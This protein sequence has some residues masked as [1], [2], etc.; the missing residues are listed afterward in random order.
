MITNCETRFADCQLKTVAWW[1][2]TLV[3]ETR[4]RF[5]SPSLLLQPTELINWLA[6]SLSLTLTTSSANNWSLH[7]LANR[8][9]ELILDL[10]NICCKINEQEATNSRPCLCKTHNNVSNWI[11]LNCTV[12]GNKNNNLGG[13]LL[14]LLLLLLLLSN[15]KL[16]QLSRKQYHSCFPHNRCPCFNN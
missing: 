2:E 13:A 14:L 15:F 9:V 3:G 5:N 6:K 4:K 11:A 12:D 10:C 16:M 7:L 8:Q 1:G